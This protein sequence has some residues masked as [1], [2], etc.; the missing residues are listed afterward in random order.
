MIGDPS[1]ITGAD[2]LPFKNRIDQLLPALFNSETLD[3]VIAGA[4]LN[5]T[6]PCAFKILNAVDNGIHCTVSAEYDQITFFS[7]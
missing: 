2:S 6:Y 3:Q 4:D 1:D 7:L 5:E